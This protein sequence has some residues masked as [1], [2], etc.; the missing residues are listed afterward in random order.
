[1][2]T[3][4]LN[5]NAN[6]RIDNKCVHLYHYAQLSYTTLNRSMD[7]W[8]WLKGILSTQIVAI[9]CLKYFKVY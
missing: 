9:S 2:E 5:Q 7:G 1:M 6:L 4:N 3:K 8:L